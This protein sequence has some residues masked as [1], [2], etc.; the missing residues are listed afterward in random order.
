MKNWIFAS[1]LFV[2]LLL[3]SSC[4]RSTVSDGAST[5]MLN[6]ALNR[7]V[8]TAVVYAG[9]LPVYTWITMADDNKDARLQVMSAAGNL[10]EV[11]DVEAVPVMDPETPPQIVVDTTG[12]LLMTYP[13]T[14]DLANKWSQMAI[15]FTRSSDGG[16][17]WS[18]P[19]TV[20]EGD[21]FG[22]YRNDHEMAI[23]GSGRIYVA[24][25]DSRFASEDE[26]GA[27]H[28]VI[29]RSD[30]EGAT[31]TQPI[32]VDESRSCECCRVALATAPDGT[33]YLAWRKILE[34]G[35]RDM[36]ISRSTDGGETW[37]DP[38]LVFA[39]DWEVD[40]CP[41]AGPSL[42]VE[43][44]DEINLAWW[45]G[46]KGKAGVKFTRSTDGG[47]SFSDPV[48]LKIT[49]ESRSSHVQLAISQNDEIFVVWDD[50]SLDMPRIA[51]AA[52]T[53]GGS[54]F[55]RP[56]YISDAGRYATYPAIASLGDEVAVVWHEHAVDEV[57]HEEQS[58][59]GT[60]VP[61]ESSPRPRIVKTSV[62]L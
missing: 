49:E 18:D 11:D 38:S 1:A 6:V 23:D 13:A 50:G 46:A 35:V 42:V 8:T 40:Y 53:D 36:V 20:G 47:D 19:V 59:T 56:K 17:T 9:D 34:P 14:G 28:V 21:S 10:V 41:D 62:G 31:W 29:A 54:S 43:N 48:E 24:W 57:L 27:S 45:T 16:E 5:E 33:V 32:L 52:S 55:S 51:L 61:N 60:W 30:D 12:D 7:G 22:G 39:D 3:T 15:R 44:N 37:S 2:S 58:F 26:L 25:L 4:T